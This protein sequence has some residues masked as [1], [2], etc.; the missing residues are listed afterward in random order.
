[1]RVAIAVLLIAFVAAACAAEAS[2][3]GNPVAKPICA[4]GVEGKRI[5]NDRKLGWL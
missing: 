2:A 3:V 5:P 4:F 1:M